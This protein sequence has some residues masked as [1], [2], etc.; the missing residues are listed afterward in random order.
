MVSCRKLLASQTAVDSLILSKVRAH[1]ILSL[2][3]NENGTGV[4]AAFFRFK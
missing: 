3:W 4:K 1:G 2:T